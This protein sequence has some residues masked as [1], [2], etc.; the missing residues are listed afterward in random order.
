MPY[1]IS[2]NLLRFWDSAQS[3][4]LSE[5]LTGDWVKA[6]DT[7]QWIIIAI[8][9]PSHRTR[10]FWHNIVTTHPFSCVRQQAARES[11]DGEKGTAT[12]W[13][14]WGVQCETTLARSPPFNCPQ[15]TV[16]TE[17]HGRWLATICYILS[18]ATSLRAPSFRWC[19]D[20]SGG[21]GCVVFQQCKWIT[22]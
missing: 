6:M 2:Q 12:S 18:H 14:N 17:P 7:F 20:I 11:G 13:H 8:I 10:S 4:M 1:K 5:S 15:A 21:L 3:A 22:N 9:F 19:E 16:T